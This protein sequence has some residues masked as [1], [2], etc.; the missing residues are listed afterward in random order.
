MKSISFLDQSRAKAKLDVI[1]SLNIRP[2]Q[3]DPRSVRCEQGQRNR[4]IA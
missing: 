2:Q 1:V 3:T 4:A